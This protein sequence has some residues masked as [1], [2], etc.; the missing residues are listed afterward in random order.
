[1]LAFAGLVFL[2]L[3]GWRLIPEN[4]CPRRKTSLSS[5]PRTASPTLVPEDRSLINEQSTA[6]KAVR[7]RPAGGRHRLRATKLF[8]NLRLRHIR[9]GD[10]PGPGAE[11]VAGLLRRPAAGAAGADAFVEEHMTSEHVAPMEAV[12]LPGSRVEGC[13][14]RSLYLRRKYGN[15]LA[16]ARE[17]TLI[18]GSAEAPARRRRAAAAGE[19]STL[20][21][22]INELGAVPR[23]LDAGQARTTGCPGAVRAGNRG[24]GLRRAHR[25]CLCGCGGR[26]A[27]AGAD[28]PAQPTSIDWLI[29]VLL[30]AMI[31][32]GGALE[33]TGATRWSPMA[34]SPPPGR[35]GRCCCSG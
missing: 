19:G 14:W 16:I 28:R 34:W 7:R 9:K 5:R 6:P 31:L 3:V 11:R 33:Q 27:A 35:W 24:D 26:H 29:I 8:G 13:S 32:L 10:I 18:D 21:D 12:I 2:L 25:D 1:M 17:G 23:A 15:L 4:R 22:T 20:P 30:G